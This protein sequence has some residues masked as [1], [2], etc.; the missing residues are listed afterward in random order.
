MSQ[1]FAAIAAVMISLISVFAGVSVMSGDVSAE[2]SDPVYL[3]HPDSPTYV[4]QGSAV[5]PVTDFT[6]FV[7]ASG[8]IVQLTFE[9]LY[10]LIDSD[11]DLRIF[12]QNGS[13][14]SIVIGGD[15]VTSLYG[16]QSSLSGWTGCST[17]IDDRM[18]D[19]EYP[20]STSGFTPNCVEGTISLSQV[21]N[22]FLIG[23]GGLVRLDLVNSGGYSIVA[24]HNPKFV[25][26]DCPLSLSFH[27]TEYIWDSS[28]SI[29]VDCLKTLGYA[30]L[31]FSDGS[32]ISGGLGSTSVFFDLEIPSVSEI[33]ELDATLDARSRSN[34]YQTVSIPVVFTIYPIAAI[35]SSS[36]LYSLSQWSDFSSTIVGN[37]PMTYSVNSGSLPDGISL[38][39][40]GVISGS[41]TESGLFEVEIV[42]FSIVG[43]SQ[44]ASISLSFE[45]E[46][47]DPPVPVVDGDISDVES[48][49]GAFGSLFWIVAGLVLLVIVLAVYSHAGGRRR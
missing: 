32:V 48:D 21:H 18:V 47:A 9:H 24:K 10:D 19:F 17:R 16:C 15:F 45:V 42:A 27:E 5:I 8:E 12:I 40:D 33:T 4:G 2:D 46:A 1:K 22:D 23:F 7:D 29:E 30:S 14:V 35:S 39:S 41:P 13:P 36:E 28:I 31:S 25:I 43:P 3:T 20:S 26:V 6:K 38:S 11:S 34:K 44:S 49:D 37:V